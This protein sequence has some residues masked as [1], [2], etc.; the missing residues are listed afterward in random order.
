VSAR[1][2]EA[3]CLSSEAIAALTNGDVCA[4]RIPDFS[5]PDVVSRLRDFLERADLEEYVYTSGA[6]ASLQRTFLGVHRLGTPYNSTYGDAERRTAYYQHA[7]PDTR[8]VRG[9]CDPYLSPIDRF[10]LELDEAWPGGAV[11]GRFDGHPMFAGM[12][13]VVGA[14]LSHLG[15][16]QPHFDSLPP[17]V[18][19]L[20]AQFST[21]IYLDVPR[22]GGEL[23]LW[24]VPPLSPAE[25]ARRRPDQDL[26]A[27]LPPPILL[28][29]RIGELIAFNTRRPHAVRAF[30]HGRRVSLQCF[31]GIRSDGTIAVWN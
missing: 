22:T 21:N 12:C 2:L 29:P 3:A 8:R 5:A 11:L 14:E 15:G 1:V 18:E 30:P 27:E 6:G 25:I 9:A 31:W 23:E 28:K 20:V 13:R 24:D 16:A 17:A 7:L 19:P 10:R 26:R 4:L